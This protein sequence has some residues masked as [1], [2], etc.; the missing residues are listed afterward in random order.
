MCIQFQAQISSNTSLPY[1]LL[2][3]A[4]YYIDPVILRNKAQAL[5]KSTGDGRYHAPIEKFNRSIFRTVARSLLRPVQMLVL[6]P[7]M[8]CLCV[9]TAILL[10]ILYLFFGAFPLVF[11]NNHG[12]SLW[13]TGLT[14]LGIFVGM[15]LAAFSDPM[16]ARLRAMLIAQRKAELAINGDYQGDDG[17]E[18]EFRLPVVIAG[19]FLVPMGM[20]WFAWTTMSSVHWIVPIIGSA[21]FGAG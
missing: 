21:V 10:G 19:G 13:Q 20:F 17:S 18:P 4:R 8:L 1:L 6:E 7:M 2:Y 5:R 14:F 3:Y 11:Q 9:Y 12:F 15:V 16:W